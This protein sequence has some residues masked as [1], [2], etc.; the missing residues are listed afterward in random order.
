M[1]PYRR[2]FQNRYR[3]KYYRR[4]WRF[5]RR[6]TRNTFQRKQW[7]RRKRSR[8]Y[9]VK[10]FRLKKKKTFLKLKQFQPKSINYCKITGFKCLFQGSPLRKQ[11]NYIQYIY[12]FVP[13]TYPGGGGWS[14]L[15]F[16]LDS[17]FE[18][19]QHLQCIW[20]KSNAG[21]PLV[22]FLGGKIKLYQTDSTDY[23][24][25]YDSC[26]PM[27]DTPHTH[28]DSAPSRIL[29]KKHKTIIPSTNTQKRKKPY[30]TI[31]FKPP[32]QMQNKWY[33]Q[34][35][36]CKIPLL[37]LTSTSIDLTKPFCNSNS[38]SNNIIIRYIN[39]YLF[40][41]NNF[42]DYPKTTGYSPK[43]L[44]D[45]PY[46][47]YASYNNT[48]PPATTDASKFKTWILRTV[49]LLNTKNY[50][51]GAM[52]SQII[53]G[54]S[55]KPENWGNPFY[56]THLDLQSTTIYL[57][58]ANTAT[59]K[60][61]INSTNFQNIRITK[62]TENM[63]YQTIYNPDNDT[64]ETNKI[65]LV[66][67]TQE[68]HFQPPT[69]TDLIFEGFP[70]YILFWGWTD[71]VRKLNKTPNIDTNYMIVIQTKTF[72]EKNDPYF[73]PIDIQFEHGYDPYIPLDTE[74][75]EPSYYNQQ[76]WYP[77]LKYQELTIENICES[78]PA[79][80]RSNNYLQA[81]CKYSFYFKW[82]G[83][84]KTLDKAYNP[85]SQ[86]KWPTTDTITPGLEITNPSE[87]PETQLYF[88]DWENDFVTQKAIQRIRDHTEPHE[89]LLSITESKA[90]AKP[91]KTTQE[92]Q[93]Q[94]EEEKLLFKLHQLRKQRMQLE[95]LIKMKEYTL[96]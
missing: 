55:D 52:M 40:Q 70:L 15:V 14:L 8:K 95:L 61:A 21:L 18:D 65:Y 24:V 78:G 85:C 68:T 72:H 87:P 3:R 75:H 66:K 48:E 29:Q 81:Y 30:K 67:A 51:S 86:P 2:Y 1:P 16:S 58:N 62:A 96:Q 20:S 4:R 42:Q 34:R 89:P 83:C 17:L 74:N 35:D 13:P 59:L 19:Y 12:S 60:T 71:F 11:H 54:T 5:P 91:Q 49:P 50:N 47:L 77:Q 45:G 36:I 31:R 41:N 10:R 33:F 28:A 38:K 53:E 80:S 92:T 43:S 64:G 93:D 9:K 69:D 84:P 23:A 46:Y 37:M 6:R 22:R 44:N 32:P 90:S 56:R 94:K 57:C 7:Y 27:V 26:W 25:V 76:N 79:V 88:W 63:I 82:G 39:P 73:V